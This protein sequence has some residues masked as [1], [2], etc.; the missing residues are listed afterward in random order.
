MAV[1]TRGDGTC[2]W[3]FC[4]GT[5]NSLLPLTAASAHATILAARMSSHS[6]HGRAEM[7]FPHPVQNRMLKQSPARR[8]LPLAL[9]MLLTAVFCGAIWLDNSTNRGVTYQASSA[10]I[11]WADGPQI[12]INAFNLHAEPDPAVITRTLEL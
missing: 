1:Y 9:A 11:P 5:S 10:P 4:S 8:L 12:G 6:L 3:Q 2:K 7:P